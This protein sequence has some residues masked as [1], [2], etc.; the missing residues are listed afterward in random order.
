M[1]R[2]SGVCF[3]WC[4]IA[5]LLKVNFLLSTP[6]TPSGSSAFVGDPVGCPSAGGR[7]MCQE[8][9]LGKTRN[10]PLKP[11]LSLLRTPTRAMP[12]WSA[13]LNAV[14]LQEVEPELCRETPCCQ[15]LLWHLSHKEQTTSP[16]G[17]RDSWPAHIKS[18]IFVLLRHKIKCFS[19]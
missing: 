10:L 3:L 15:S 17:L 16:Q 1:Y 7:D 11:L 4:L 9:W 12:M 8:A 6:I 13:A 19:Q 5:H 18:T 2:N 14:A